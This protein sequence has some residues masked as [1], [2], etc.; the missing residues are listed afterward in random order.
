MKRRSK[1]RIWALQIIYM[2]EVLGGDLPEIAEDHL[3][4]KRAGERGRDYT[5][6][7]ISKIN[8]ELRYID[9]V[10]E[11]TLTSWPIER[12]SVID[13]NILRIGTCELLYFIDVPPAVV[14]DEAI[15][16]AIAYGG[17]DSSKFINGILD[18]I[19]KARG[20]SGCTTE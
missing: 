7:L 20:G 18:S 16:L 19:Y 5:L 4:K 9:E 15:E 11:G 6:R 10:I 3:D 2:W 8:E 14:I 1:S 17:S 12:L 13:K